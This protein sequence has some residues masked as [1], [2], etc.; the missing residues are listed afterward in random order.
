MGGKRLVGLFLLLWMSL[1]V[2]GE[3]ELMNSFIR[4]IISTFNLTLPTV[5]YDSNEAPEICYENTPKRRVLCLQITEEEQTISIDHNDT[6]VYI[7][8]SNLLT[9]CM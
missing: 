1:S 4:D 5:I 6:G 3:E 8:G 7:Q 9:E 2:S